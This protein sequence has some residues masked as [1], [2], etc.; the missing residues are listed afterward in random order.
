MN[1]LHEDKK[2]ISRIAG[3]IYISV[4]VGYYALQLSELSV[5]S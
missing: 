5:K 2:G 4:N 3:T 1:K